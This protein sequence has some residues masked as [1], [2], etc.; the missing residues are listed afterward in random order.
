L[1]KGT[2]FFLTQSLKAYL[3]SGWGCG[4]C[5]DGLRKEIALTPL[6]RGKIRMGVKGVRGF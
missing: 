4:H 3:I 2:L 6:G 1:L 5:P